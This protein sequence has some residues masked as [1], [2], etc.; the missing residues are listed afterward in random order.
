MSLFR[1]SQHRYLILNYSSPW[2][3]CPPNWL[4]GQVSPNGMKYFQQSDSKSI[5]QNPI[6]GTLIY[7]QLVEFQE[8]EQ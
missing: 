4:M 1:L 5:K 6:K 2:T 7:S 8:Q 3:N